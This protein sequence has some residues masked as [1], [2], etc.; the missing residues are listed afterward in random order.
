MVKRTFLSKPQ[1]Q[2][3]K[4]LSIGM[5]LSKYNNQDSLHKVVRGLMIDLLLIAKNMDW[6]I[7]PDKLAAV[8]S[9]MEIQHKGIKRIVQL[10]MIIIIR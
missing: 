10:L 3:I 9:R 6:Q 1:P 2:A 5:A 8:S 7:I 4:C